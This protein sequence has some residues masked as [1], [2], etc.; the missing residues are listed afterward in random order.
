MWNHRVVNVK[1]ENGGEDWFTIREVFY[2][3]GKPV[4]YT[5]AC[6]GSET[7]EGLRLTYERM[8]RALDLPVL[9]EDMTEVSDVS[10]R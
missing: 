5:D 7:I 3:D 6:Y 10:S 9:N 8:I 4:G 1:S 2:E